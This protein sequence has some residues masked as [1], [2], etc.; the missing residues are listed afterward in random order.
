[1][2]KCDKPIYIDVTDDA[3]ETTERISDKVSID[4]NCKGEVCGV[5]VLEN[6]GM[7]FDGEMVIGIKTDNINQDELVEELNNM[8]EIVKNYGCIPGQVGLA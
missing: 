4:Y 7:D 5:E 6:T 3:V 1:M 2:M 8:R